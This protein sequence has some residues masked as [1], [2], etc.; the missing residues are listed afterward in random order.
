[1]E[2]TVIFYNNKKC[3]EVALLIFF[4]RWW[5][6]WWWDWR[7][8]VVRLVRLA[9]TGGKTGGETGPPLANS[10]TMHSRMICKDQTS[11]FSLLKSKIILSS[12]IAI[13]GG[14]DST[15]SLSDLWKRVFL[16]GTEPQIHR[17]TLQPVDWIG[18]RADS[19]KR[20]ASIWILS[21]RPWA[22]T[23]FYGNHDEL[24]NRPGV[25]GA[26]L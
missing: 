7:R 6:W 2:R 1:M 17:Q 9:E 12:K 21:K 18:L 19:V 4:V 22:L 11:Q 5:W 23:L 15:K 3:G 25:A 16:D 14:H 8:L 20:F 26:V 13:L 24:I 10:P